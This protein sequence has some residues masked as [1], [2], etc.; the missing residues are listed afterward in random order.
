MLSLGMS[1]VG[2]LL[3]ML[4]QPLFTSKDSVPDKEPWRPFTVVCYLIES[5]VTP[6]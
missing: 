4:L 6:H 3:V 2:I 1:A 5:Q